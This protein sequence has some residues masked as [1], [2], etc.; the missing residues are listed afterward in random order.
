MCMCMLHVACTHTA[1]VFDA[2]LTHSQV[3]GPERLGDA[4]GY[5]SS[6]LTP[7]LVMR[8]RL[9]EYVNRLREDDKEILFEGVTPSPSSSLSS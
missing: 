5:V 9:R 8:R 6:A 2:C 1:R 4:L 3:P 7:T